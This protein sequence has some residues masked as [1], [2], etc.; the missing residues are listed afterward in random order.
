MRATRLSVDQVR[1]VDH[2]AES[3][4]IMFPHA[5]G[6]AIVG[7]SLVRDDYRDVDIRIIAEDEKVRTLRAILDLDDLHMLLSR[8]GQQVTGLPIDCQLQ[9]RSEHGR[10]AYD[11]SGRPLH[12]WRG[13]GRL[14]TNARRLRA[15]AEQETL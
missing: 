14:G 4:F 8:W 5:M 11:E 10:L 3:L 9:E 15:A 12:H 6:V 2:F 7:S 13:N 1:A